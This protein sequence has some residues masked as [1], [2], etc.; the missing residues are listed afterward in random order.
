MSADRIAIVA[1]LFRW[2]YRHSTA[3]WHA[4]DR[5]RMD[6]WNGVFNRVCHLAVKA[7]L[8]HRDSLKDR[9]LSY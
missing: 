8:M 1:R 5:Q 2:S 9:P 3:A 6:Y 7:G 4:Q